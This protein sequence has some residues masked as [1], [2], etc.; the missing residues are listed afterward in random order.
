MRVK[1]LE[2]TVNTESDNSH[3]APL[4]RRLTGL[5]E[6]RMEGRISHASR[7]AG[8][9]MMNG[10]PCLYFIQASRPD[11]D[12]I[13]LH[14]TVT[15]ERDGSWF[16][17]NWIFVKKDEWT[18][19]S[20]EKDQ[21]PLAEGRVV[22]ELEDA[23]ARLSEEGSLTRPHGMPEGRQET[24]PS[25]LN[26][27]RRGLRGGY[28][29]LAVV[30]LT[31]G[32]FM[33]LCLFGLQY[34][35]MVRVVGRLE[36]AIS[37]AADNQENA[38]TDLTAQMTLVNRELRVLQDDVK[39]ERQAFEFSRVNT[40]MNLRRLSEELPGRYWSRKQAY[41]YL[42]DR[43]ENSSSY[44]ELIY[45]LSRLPEDNA[46]AETLMATDRENIIPLSTYVPVFPGMVYPVR[47]DG[48]RNDG[49]DFMISS[50][51]RAAAALAG[52]IEAEKI[53]AREKCL[54]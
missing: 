4:V 33:A 13:V 1:E 16:S 19:A 28:A 7:I 11:I 53:R 9:Y 49:A 3:T 18:L 54:M 42:A 40:A 17:R 20:G 24:H 5:L 36:S 32:F 39:R 34:E 45:Q 2:G 26:V 14:E 43:V 46:Q 35:R 27:L 6:K 22:S 47:V 30:S 10:D 41:L 44:G 31:G 38:V 12:R 23:C 48:E 50:D 51:A 37:G 15:S 25:L 8:G 29:L 21:K 52:G